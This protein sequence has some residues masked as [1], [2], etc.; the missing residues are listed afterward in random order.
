METRAEYFRRKY[1][2]RYCHYKSPTIVQMHE[3]T[4][5]HNPNRAAYIA[6]RYGVGHITGASLSRMVRAD[7]VMSEQTTL[8]PPPHDPVGQKVDNI[9]IKSEK[10][11]RVKKSSTPNTAVKDNL[12]VAYF[13]LDTSF[14]A[15]SA[16]TSEPLP[17][18]SGD[19]V[20]SFFST[21]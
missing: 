6:K 13:P 1:T 10:K 8:Q 18:L 5:E 11:V 7:K 17:I 2:C 19:D 20:V 15:F 16:I 3:R 4:C 14:T 21:M 9:S 12:A